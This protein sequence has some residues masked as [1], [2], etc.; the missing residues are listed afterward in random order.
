MAAALMFAGAAFAQDPVAIKFKTNGTQPSFSFIIGATEE[1]YIDV[2]CGYG[3][4]EYLVAPA[5]WDE[6]TLSITGTTVGCQI[7]ESCEVTIYG[8]PSLINYFFSEGAYIESIDLGECYNLEILDLQ[9][10]VL[11][12]LDLSPYTKLAA[13]YLSDNPFTAETPLVVGNNHPELMIL[14]VD[15]I[16]Y[17]SP[18]FD[19]NTYPKLLSFDGYANKTLTHLDPTNCPNLMRLSVDMCPIET[20]DV[21][22]NPEL[23]ILNISDSKITD[24]DLS[25]NT[26]LVQLFASHES[27]WVN[28]EHKLNSLDITHNTELTVLFANGNNFS[29]I[30]LSSCSALS[31]VVLSNCQ[32]EALDVS[33]NNAI[34]YL[35]IAKNNMSFATLPFP[36]TNYSEYY[37]EQRP[38]PVERSYPIGQV[39]DFSDRVLREGTT[40]DCVLYGYSVASDQCTVLEPKYYSYSDGR[41]TL[42]KE[43]PDSVFAAFGNSAFPDA[44]MTTGKFMV[45]TDQEY[46]KPTTIISMTAGAYKGDKFTVFVGLDGASASNPKAYTIQAGDQYYNG[47]ATAAI[48]GSNG[49]EC[50][51][52]AGSVI[53]V[54]IP[55]GS[56]LT[57]FAIDGV[58]LYSVNLSKATELR[59]LK[60]MNAGLY[61]ID[62]A[63]NRCLTELNL[64]GNNLRSLNLAGVCE[65]YNKNVLSSISVCNNSLNDIT[66]NATLAIKELRLANNALTEFNYKDFDNLQVLD[67]SGNALTSLNMDYMTET[68]YCNLANNKFES[69]KL[70]ASNKFAELNI[71]GN[72]LTFATLPYLPAREGLVYTYAPQMPITIPTRGPGIDLSSQNVTIAGHSTQFAWKK[73]DGTVLTEGV[74]YRIN[75]GRTKFIN[76]SVGMIYCAM[77]NGAFPAFAGEDA[78]STTYIKADEMPTN[79]IATFVTPVGGQNVKLSLAGNTA[80]IAVYFDWEGKNDF[81]D[82]YLLNTTYTLYSATTTEGATVN[83]YTY[84]PTEKVTVFSINGASMSSF[85]GSGLNGVQCLTLINAGLKGLTFPTNVETLTE[86]NLDNNALETFDVSRFPE[87]RSLS[88]SG[89]K[90]TTLDFSGAPNL[91]VAS[92]ALNSLNEVKFAK[93]CGLWM[94][95]LAAND[96]YDIDLSPLTQL[97]QVSLSNNYLSSIDLSANKQIRVLQIDGNAF[98]F[99]TLPLPKSSWYVYNFGNQGPMTVECVDSK[100]DLSSEAVING[101]NTEYTWYI[102]VPKF[103]E[104]GTLTGENLYLNE[105]YTLENGVT[106]FLYDFNDVMCVMTNS[107]FPGL[108]QHTNPISVQAGVKNVLTDT[109][110]NSFKV[111]ATGNGNVSVFTTLPEGTVVTAVTVDGKAVAT[112]SVANGT[113]TLNAPAGAVIITAGSH[114]AKVIV[115]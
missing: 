7:S 85:D 103:D 93:G 90:L 70:P 1:T 86:L 41:L 57:S 13:I 9:H 42:L 67:L 25:K 73:A 40:T 32:L 63:Y 14:E 112:A 31:Y 61:S 113:A 23:L 100:V 96:L 12:A 33:Q 39:L 79:R 99:S 28:K 115:R 10:N 6:E 45:K 58:T 24:I 60:L 11:K 81:L 94:L 43:Y 36:S 87:L 98:T 64:D 22:K 53:N 46:G 47:Y 110:G 26:K 102:G 66:L 20:L 107:T 72:K 44:V 68:V 76:T 2:D 3:P 74:D 50:T 15:I 59:S 111:V 62:L 4:V 65:A 37:Y 114:A 18:D 82:Q 17:I 51:M 106:T 21:T 88:V 55:E 91:Q 89:N 109:E 69:I 35:N 30:D 104:Y 5:V 34:N 95:N 54:N 92:A 19:I 78:L 16:D 97:E 56:V 77:T 52:G 71:S 101:V 84:E 27:G 48:E 8:D 83:V 75:N 29:S 38:M 105:E 49:L 108:Y 80:G